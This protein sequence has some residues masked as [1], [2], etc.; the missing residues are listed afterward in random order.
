M[1]NG[2]QVREMIQIEGI[3]KKRFSVRIKGTTP[4]IVHRFSE[5]AKRD[6]IITQEGKKIK[7]AK[8]DTKQEYLDCIHW[9]DKKKDRSGFPAGGFKE[10]IC[11]GGKHMPKMTMVDA[12]TSFHITGEPGELTELVEIFG[13][14]R[15]REDHVRLP[16]GRADVR[17]RA[18]YPEWSAQLNIIYNSE[19]IS[20][21]QLLSMIENAGF[22]CGIGEWRPQKSASGSFGLWEID[23]DDMI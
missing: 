23:M 16:N 7:R 22:A 4:L 6:I 12:R 11:R 9:I 10:A 18:E 8:R 17:Y 2:T 19:Q 14:H 5:K 1:E 3:R 13:K 20:R 21:E 15:M